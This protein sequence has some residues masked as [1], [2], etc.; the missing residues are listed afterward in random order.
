MTVTH[1]V[2]SLTSCYL[3][4]VQLKKVIKRVANELSELGL[5]SE[6]LKD[7][8]EN[9][10]EAIPPPALSELSPDEAANVVNVTRGGVSSGRTTPTQTGT[11][12]SGG[13]N[14]H[15][16]AEG[17]S[18]EDEDEAQDFMSGLKK[19]FKGKKVAKPK[20]PRKRR[21]HATYEFAG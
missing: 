13:L 15:A 10:Y 17:D 3:V 6:V 11:K 12:A 8:L 9:N 2:Q 1:S 21:A 14:G 7:L 20:G 16:K 18:S 5:T 19:D 4:V